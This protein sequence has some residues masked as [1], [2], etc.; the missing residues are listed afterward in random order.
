MRSDHAMVVELLGAGADVNL[1]TKGDRT[2]LMMAVE[3][4]EWHEADVDQ[5]VAIVNTLVDA[6]VSL[7]QESEGMTALAL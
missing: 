2:A 3:A 6:G 5:A 4:Q 1:A 7:E